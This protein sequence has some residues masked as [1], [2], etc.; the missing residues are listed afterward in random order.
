MIKVA[1]TGASGFIGQH[2]LNYLNNLSV[3][4][5][6]ITRLKHANLPKLVNGLW[7]EFDLQN[8]PENVFSLMGNPDVLI[9]LA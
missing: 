7:V 5:V 3:D 2:V 9:H 6:A 8:P 4:V 1:V